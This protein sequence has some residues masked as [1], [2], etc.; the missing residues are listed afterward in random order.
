M[1]THNYYSYYVSAFAHIFDSS[2]FYLYFLTI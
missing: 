2:D 1:T